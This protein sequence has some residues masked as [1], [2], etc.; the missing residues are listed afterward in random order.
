M[1]AKLEELE[2]QL[3][4]ETVAPPAHCRRTLAFALSRPR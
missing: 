3:G 2:R 1:K 4:G